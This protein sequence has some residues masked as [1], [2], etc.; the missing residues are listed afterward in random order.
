MLL[1]GQLRTNRML[2]VW[3][4]NT[5]INRY[6][7]DVFLAID[8]TN[9]KQC[10]YKNDANDTDD[11]FIEET[12][13]FYDP[14]NY[15]VNTNYDEIYEKLLDVLDNNTKNDM[16][17]YRLDL[18]FSQ[19]YV[20]MKGYEL[21]TE[22]IKNTGTQY[23]VVVRLRFDQF[24]FTKDCNFFNI[25]DC[26]IN[27]EIIYNEQNQKTLEK[28]SQ[29]YCLTIIKPQKNEIYF[30]GF[31]QTELIDNNNIIYVY[32]YANDQF[33]VH[34]PELIEKVQSFYLMMIPLVQECFSE[35][36]SR[37]LLIERMF[38]NYFNK[39]SFI[40]K[41]HYIGIFIREYETHQKI[42]S[43]NATIEIIF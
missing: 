36:K 43:D 20:V 32:N 39:N 38:Y 29:H 8:K 6:D 41:G 13:K 1:T 24:I 9:N 30:L 31:G 26:G 22:H 34:G 35:Q 28:I 14:I 21:I 3:M 25:L 4:K 18:I 10:V 7:T 42:Y 33:F 16:I 15:F 27:N 40:N 11:L 19:Y 37:R 23:D 2:R 5:L 12:I 17:N